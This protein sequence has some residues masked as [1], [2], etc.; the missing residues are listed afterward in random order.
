[1]LGRTFFA[2]DGGRI[3]LFRTDRKRAIP[4]RAVSSYTPDAQ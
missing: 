3:V 2:A 1:M 4:G